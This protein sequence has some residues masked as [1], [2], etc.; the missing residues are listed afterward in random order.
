MPE[1]QLLCQ[2]TEGLC[3]ATPTKRA[4]SAHLNAISDY[5]WM[6]ADE[7]FASTTARNRSGVKSRRNVSVGR[8][9]NFFIKM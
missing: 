2:L 7:L 5:H 9:E 4:Q 6:A 8:Q 3:A 1:F